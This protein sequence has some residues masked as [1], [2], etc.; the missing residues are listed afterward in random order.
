MGLAAGS[1]DA[2]EGTSE[3]SSST[4]RTA[5]A[6]RLMPPPPVPGR[7]PSID[8]GLARFDRSIWLEEEGEVVD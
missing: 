8:K 5:I 7:I 3:A 1:D 4:S 6:L 2:D